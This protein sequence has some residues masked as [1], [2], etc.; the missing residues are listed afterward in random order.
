[1]SQNTQPI[2]TQTPHVDSCG[3]LLTAAADY[4]GQGAANAVAFVAGANGSFIASIRFKAMGTNVASVAR[5]FLNA[6][7]TSPK[8]PVIA[9]V[10]GTPTGTPSSS[11]GTLQTG[12]YY[13][14]IYA[15]DELGS[16]TAASTETASV[17]VTGPTGSIAWAWTAVTG[18]VSYIV[19][20]GLATGQEQV[21]FTSST[22]SYTQTGPGYVSNI[23][24]NFLLGDI[25]NHNYFIGE[26][27]LPATTLIA[28]AATIDVEYPINRA[29]PPG[30][31]IIIGLGTTVA[32]GW[33]PTVFGGD[34]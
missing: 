18:A 28:T 4:T 26:V 3:A 15:V 12:S 2:F 27:S 13:A 29:I 6:D 9:A 7:G 16:T 1:M 14:K 5:I 17:S 21:A 20:V 30:A 33:V 34:Y 23:S 10:S 32:A 31:M 11:G 22:N 8:A 19:A 25:S 24:N